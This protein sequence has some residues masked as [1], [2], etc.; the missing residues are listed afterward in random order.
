[1]KIQMPEI[2]PGLW[3]IGMHPGPI[4]YGERGA[5]VA[6]LCEAMVP[7]PEHRENVRAIAAVPELL[8]ALVDVWYFL[9]DGTL[10]EDI[11]PQEA[12]IRRKIISTLEA[13]G[14]RIEP[15]TPAGDS[16]AV[17]APSNASNRHLARLKAND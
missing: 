7:D 15:E 2:T 16:D 17:A 10:P 4:V 5:Q 1:M 12:G 6:D 14:C 9:D 13:A 11:P 8:R 3:Y